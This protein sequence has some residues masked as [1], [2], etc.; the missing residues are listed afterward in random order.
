MNWMGSLVLRLGT[1]QFY[2]SFELFKGKWILLEC[3][4]QA[5]ELNA[6]FLFLKEGT[7]P[8]FGGVFEIMVHLSSTRTQ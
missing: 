3:I 6:V 7:H 5:I 2:T 4:Y 8:N 1:S